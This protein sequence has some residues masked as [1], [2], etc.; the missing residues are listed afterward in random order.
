M[1]FHIYVADSFVP[2]YLDMAV[3]LLY[4]IQQEGHTVQLTKWDGKSNGIS[5][6]ESSQIR[7]MKITANTQVVIFGCLFTQEP[8]IL[9]DG[10][11]VTIFDCAEVMKNYMDS[12]A[13]RNN[14]ILHYT[15]SDVGKYDLSQANLIFEKFNF[16]Y[17]PYID[18]SAKYPPMQDPEYDVV[19]VGNVS[20]RRRA[21]L[22]QLSDLG[23]SVFN[24]SFGFSNPTNSIKIHKEIR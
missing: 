21:I 2:M 19:F 18:F 22:Q 12:G 5:P 11:V 16:I 7:R 23:L 9:P 20:E 13:L 4:Q 15:P 6:V 8:W 17:S 1:H 3:M 24:F 14:V 10:A